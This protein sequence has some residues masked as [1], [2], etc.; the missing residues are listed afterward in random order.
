[1]N[2]ITQ[3]ILSKT[4]EDG[5]YYQ[6][7][8]LVG[9]KFTSACVQME[10]SSKTIIYWKKINMPINKGILIKTIGSYAMKLVA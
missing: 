4:A 2:W 1:M 10:F 7:K 8:L 9:S 3:S 6:Y 5:S